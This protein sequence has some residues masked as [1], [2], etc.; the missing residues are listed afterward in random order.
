MSHARQGVVLSADDHMSGTVAQLRPEAG[1]EAVAA[2][3]DVEAYA[4]D[5]DGVLGG[6]PTDLCQTAAQ[7]I[8]SLTNAAFD[9]TLDASGLAA[10]DEIDVRITI[11]ITDGAT[12]TA[13]I[14][15]IGYVALIAD[16]KG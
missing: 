3:V 1:G 10:E 2:T 12:A 4:V 7:S 8:N 6:S 9:F 11:A 16:I 13:V 14:G 15:E 5:G